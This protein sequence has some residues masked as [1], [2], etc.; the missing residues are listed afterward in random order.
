[1]PAGWKTLDSRNNLLTADLLEE[2]EEEEEEKKKLN[3][4]Q[5]T[6]WLQS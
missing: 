1:M 4:K 2:E 6:R 3:I 5:T